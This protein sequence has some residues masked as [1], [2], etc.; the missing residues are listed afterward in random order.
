LALCR[1]CFT[2]QVDKTHSSRCVICNKRITSAMVVDWTATNSRVGFQK[3][4]FIEKVP[5]PN[6]VHAKIL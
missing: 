6:H 5:K 2:K 3:R 1:E 4:W